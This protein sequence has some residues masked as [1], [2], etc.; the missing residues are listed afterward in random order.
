VNCSCSRFGAVPDDARNV[1]GK[2][3]YFRGRRYVSLD[4]TGVDFGGCWSPG[5]SPGMTASER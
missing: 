3:T 4:G 5:S 2:R 1:A